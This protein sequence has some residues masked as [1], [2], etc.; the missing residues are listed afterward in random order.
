[1]T[2]E[3][4]VIENCFN[5]QMI[6]FNQK[7]LL[8][9]YVNRLHSNNVPVIYNLRHI[10]KLFGISKKEQDKFFGHD[11]NS[12]YKTFYIPKK[13][14]SYRKIEAP[15]EKLEFIQSW[16]KNEIVDKFIISDC[17]KGFKKGTS[18]VDNALPHCNKR[19]I[20][21][22]DIKD[23][24]PSIKYD[25]IF[26]MFNYIGYT[27][28]VCHLLTKLCTNNHNVLPQGS[29]AS[30]SISNLVNLKLDKRLSK[31]SEHIGASYTRYA[32]DITF[33]GDKSLL[34]Y[35]DV[36]VK[37]I[38]DEH[39]EINPKKFRVSYNNQRQEVTGLIVNNGV[40]PNKRIISE[41]NNAIYYISKFGLQN[42]LDHE[43][44]FQSAYKEH[45][46]GLAYFVNMVDEVK[47]KYYLNKL[48]NLNWRS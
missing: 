4:Q 21:N 36:I 9:A 8:T 12:L 39:Y 42:H 3:L 38:N 1:M 37:I 31:L 14:G 43:K 26:R 41:L 15:T 23:F 29:P 11:R 10:R 7:E 40:T 28:E 24:F 13:S 2:E 19:V 22:I 17:A 48:D 20:L 45:L 46:Y 18:I 34:H 5:N 44:I 6:D 25:R 27:N 47:G 35:K 32:D 16:I 30:P 33:S